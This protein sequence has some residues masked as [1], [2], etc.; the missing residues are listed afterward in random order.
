MKEYQCYDPIGPGV[1][2][3]APETCCLFCDH[4]YDVWWDYTHGP[5][6]MFCEVHES[7]F[8]MEGPQ[9]KC[10]DFTCQE[11]ERDNAEA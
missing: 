5:Y 6:T 11:G 7:P 8:D 1:V 3:R 2:V 4:C 9:G 10:P